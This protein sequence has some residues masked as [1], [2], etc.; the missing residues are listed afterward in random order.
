MTLQ[1][2]ENDDHHKR[3]TTTMSL[4]GKGKVQNKTFMRMKAMIKIHRS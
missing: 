4:R 2:K 3:T 1:G